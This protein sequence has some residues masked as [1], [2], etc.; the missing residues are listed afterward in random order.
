MQSGIAYRF[1][2]CSVVGSSIRFSSLP[3]R[4]TCPILSILALSSVLLISAEDY[5][6][7]QHLKALPPVDDDKVYGDQIRRTMHLLSTSTEEAPN[8]VKILFFGQSITRQNY[9]RRII[10]ASLR[11]RFPQAELEVLNTAIGGYQSPRSVRTM[12]HTLI[13]H[14]P[15]LVVFH[16]YGGENDGSYEQIL[17]NIRRYTTAELICVT[18]HLDNYNKERTRQKEAA[19]ELR[20]QLADKYGAELIE[21]RGDWKRYMDQHGFPVTEFLSD[22]IHH[23]VHGGELWGALQERH[24]RVVETDPESWQDRITSIDLSKME[25]SGSLGEVSIEGG[26]RFEKGVG[27]IL[28]NDGQS[29]RLTFRGTRVDLISRGGEGEAVVMIDGRR[30]SDIAETW[31]ATLPS[32]TPIDYRPAIMKVGLG[33]S[34]VDETWT[35]TFDEVSEDG[36]DFAYDVTG[37]RSG[38][39]G[40]GSHSKVFRSANG[41]IEL[42][43]SVFTLSHAIQIKKK[44][45]KTPF[46]VTWKV[47]NRSLDRWVQDSTGGQVTLVQQL[48]N[49][50]HV[51]E[52]KRRSG[53]FQIEKILIYRPGE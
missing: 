49:G 38:P 46:S 16:V 34:P 10:E 7:F 41:I 20:R 50:E 13:P 4:F 8:R 29:M 25:T 3:M 22:N 5:F 33:G 6:T 26:G 17:K 36:R 24:F 32:S 28:D 52:V 15:D 9:S 39:Q 2:L 31:S 47:E 12:F 48:P 11:Q 35:V 51:L 37:S 42:D 19:S 45:L 43:P 18:H 44:P 30:P 27:L 53:S 23:N 40:R 1:F 14:Q 21:V